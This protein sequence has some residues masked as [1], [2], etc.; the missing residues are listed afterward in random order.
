MADGREREN[1]GQ[2]LGQK[3]KI[4]PKKSGRSK[5]FAHSTYIYFLWFWIHHLNCNCGSL[6]VSV[7]VALD[8]MS[9]LFGLHSVF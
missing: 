5:H 9:L 6:A 3:K 8:I 7:S 4:L 1:G 2:W